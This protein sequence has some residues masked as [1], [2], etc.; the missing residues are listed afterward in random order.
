MSSQTLSGG[1]AC[2]PLIRAS[3]SWLFHQRD[4]E[5]AAIL[6]IWS[7]CFQPIVSDASP[8]R[9]LPMRPVSAGAGLV[10]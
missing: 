1:F 8:P 5:S 9:E 6:W 2:V 4:G 7:E 10:R 3:V